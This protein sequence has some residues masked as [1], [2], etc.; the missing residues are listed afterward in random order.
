MH[1]REEIGKCASACNNAFIVNIQHTKLTNT[2]S[3]SII[4]I[5]PPGHR[6]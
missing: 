4:K 3:N 1:H 6:M 2:S 5:L